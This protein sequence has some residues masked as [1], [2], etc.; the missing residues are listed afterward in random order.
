MATVKKKKPTTNRNAKVNSLKKVEQ[1]IS[2]PGKSPKKKVAEEINFSGIG[3]GE[4]A[5]KS[6]IFTRKYLYV[7]AIIL[8]VI[9]LLFAASRFWVIAW[10]DNKPVTKF[11]LFALLE[12][13]DN[14][15]TTEELIVESLLAS[16]GSKKRQ[17]VN[18]EEVLTEIKKIEDQQGGAQQLDQILSIRGL[19]KDDFKKLVKQQLLIQK[20]FGEGISITEEDIDKYIKDNEDTLTPEVLGAPESSEAAKLREGIKEQLKWGKVNE[21]YNKWLQE[22]LNGSRVIRN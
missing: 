20:L 13:R 15:K 19:N 1:K 3:S 21:N 16:E 10:V 6:K 2:S 9:G 17:V 8:A 4:K 7:S 14:G 12:K 11:A 5:P 18:E 22:N